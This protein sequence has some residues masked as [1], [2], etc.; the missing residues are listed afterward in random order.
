MAAMRLVPGSLELTSRGCAGSRHALAAALTVRAMPLAGGAGVTAVG[1]V[2]GCEVRTA[3]AGTGRALGRVGALAAPIRALGFMVLPVAL[4]ATPTLALAAL[5]L[6]APAL[7]LAAL[8][9]ALQQLKQGKANQVLKG[10]RRVQERTS[11]L[12]AGTGPAVHFAL[13]GI[14]CAAKVVVRTALALEPRT[15]HWRVAA[16]TGHAQVL[17]REVQAIEAGCQAFVLGLGKGRH[18][19]VLRFEVQQVNTGKQVQEEPPCRGRRHLCQAGIQGCFHMLQAM[20]RQQGLNLLQDLLERLNGSQGFSQ[21]LRLP[22]SSKLQRTGQPAHRNARQRL[23]RQHLRDLGTCKRLASLT[24]FATCAPVLAALALALALLLVVQPL[25]EGMQEGRH[26]HAPGFCCFTLRLRWPLSVLRVCGQQLQSQSQPPS[27][28]REVCSLLRL[29]KKVPEG[30]LAEHA[31][32]S[33]IILVPRR[34]GPQIWEEALQAAANP[35]IAQV[36]Q[37]APADFGTQS[38]L[39]HSHAANRNESNFEFL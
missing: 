20:R 39:Q 32:I 24:I 15:N 27:P 8:A 16:V 19:G 4:P 9:H 14:A 28:D 25:Q 38:G 7:V 18:E 34:V 30:A 12:M 31:S 5:A 3:L 13:L 35:G 23:R 10:T 1:G 26:E 33:F 29:S 11:E 37:Q 6:P 2:P 21:L 22:L 36:I 17:Q